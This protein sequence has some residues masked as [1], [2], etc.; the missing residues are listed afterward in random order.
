VTAFTGN[1][2]DDAILGVLGTELGTLVPVR[3]D[4]ASFER[5]PDERVVIQGPFPYAVWRSAVGDDDKPRLSG[6][7]GVLSVPFWLTYVG[8]T[9]RQAKW[10]GAK[11]RF[12]LNHRRIAVPGHKTGTV[13]LQESARIW[14][15]DEAVNPLGKSLFY[16]VDSY[17]VTISIT[18]FKGATA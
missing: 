18:E 16:G 7:K 10:A 8:E 1:E 17:A 11:L 4:R 3:E 14:R 15:D 13:R 6:H 9:H 12:A 2:V 5:T